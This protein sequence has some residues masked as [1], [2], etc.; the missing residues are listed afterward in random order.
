MAKWIFSLALVAIAVNAHAQMDD[1]TAC[2]QQKP[3]HQAKLVAEHAVQVKAIMTEMLISAYGRYGVTLEQKQIIF[4][5]PQSTLVEDSLAKPAVDRLETVLVAKV[6]AGPDAIKAQAVSNITAIHAVER[7]TETDAL[8]RVL[9]TRLICT[10][11]SD[12]FAV[13]LINVTSK[14]R[15]DMSEDNTAI[16]IVTELP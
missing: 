7:V 15:I 9:G 14:Q 12:Y 13:E 4:G 16:E 10:M 3:L 11:A 8:G 6:D 1:E 2:L 5:P